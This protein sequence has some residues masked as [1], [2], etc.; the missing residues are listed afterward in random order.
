[1]KNTND[2][3]KAYGSIWKNQKKN[4]IRDEAVT[5]SQPNTTVTAP[6]VCGSDSAVT[7][8]LSTPEAGSEGEDTVGVSTSGVV[9]TSMWNGAWKER[10]VGEGGEWS[11]CA[12]G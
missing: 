1:M 7:A 9:D 5:N 12:D 10:E 3:E 11:L 6:S 2:S 8:G 4:S